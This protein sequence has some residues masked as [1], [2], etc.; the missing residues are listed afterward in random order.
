M[1]R[2]GI[3]PIDELCEGFR[4]RSTYVITGGAGAGKTT[5]G[6]QFVDQ[7]LRSGE[8][9]VMLT[10]ASRDDLLGHAEYLGIELRPALREGRAVILRYRSDF[11][12]RL[13]RTG[14]AAAALEELRAIVGKHRPKR[15]VLDTFAPL[16]E[17]GSSSAVAATTLVELLERSEATALL[18][19]SDDLA[20]RYDR[21][22]EPLVQSA[23][24]V[25]SLTRDNAGMRWV[26]VVSLRHQ[27]PGYAGVGARQLAESLEA[28]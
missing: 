14:T 3:V 12:L 18:T 23:A 9:V 22:L 13:A 21:R 1:I 11:A 19:Y 7:G 5:Y 26:E 16:L 10:H 25:F 28:R 2:S 15:I 8:A 17:D 20:A 24:G 6:L 4:P 27:R